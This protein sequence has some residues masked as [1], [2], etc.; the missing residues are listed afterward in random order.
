MK[1]DGIYYFIRVP[2]CRTRYKQI[3]H[4]GITISEF[5]AVYK[6][7]KNK[8]EKYIVFRKTSYYYSFGTQRF[9]HA[10]ELA[11]NKIVTRLRF[12]P[13]YPQRTYGAF[14]GYSLLINFSENFDRLTILFFKGLQEAAPNLFQ[15]WQVGK[16]A[17]IVKA[18][19]VRLR[20]EADLSEG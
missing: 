15:R 10:I 14:K 20:Y 16:I 19:M 4:K 13:E 12:I 17:E 7:G 9:T 1:P 5:P 11:G 2:E 18:D 8:G 3:Q 6:R